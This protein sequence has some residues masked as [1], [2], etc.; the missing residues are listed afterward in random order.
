MNT[1]QVNL[2]TVPPGAATDPIAQAEKAFRARKKKERPVR[3]PEL[4][5]HLRLNDEYAA[6]KQAEADDK[7]RRKKLGLPKKVKSDADKA[8]EQAYQKRWLQACRALVL[9]D[10]QPPAFADL[11]AEVRRRA[12]EPPGT[13]SLRA[14]REGWDKES[15]IFLN[16][17]AGQ[18]SVAMLVLA[19]LGLLP[20]WMRNHRLV[21]MFADVMCER[22]STYALLMHHLVPFM[23]RHR[24]EFRWLKPQGYYF[25]LNT[26]VPALAWLD[27]G[28]AQTE[29]TSEFHVTKNRV[30]P[31]L[32]HIY[33][34]DKHPSFPMWNS[35]ARCNGNS[36]HGVLARAR[37]FVRKEMNGRGAKSQT[38][39]GFKDWVLLGIAQDEPKRAEPTMEQNY[40]ILYPLIGYQLGREDC[41]QLILAAGL[42]PVE[43]SGCVT[44]FAAPTWER[45]YVSQV[46]PEVFSQMVLMENLSIA[47][48]VARGLQ[49]N[50]IDLEYNLPLEEAVAAYQRDNAN[51]TVEMCADWL[52][53][54]TY[55]RDDRPAS[56][57]GANPDQLSFDLDGLDPDDVLE[58]LEAVEE[59][60]LAE[61][62]D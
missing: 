4:E 21:I 15:V 23:Q 17:G 62:G 11:L 41:L 51:V 28:V 13:Y 48:R 18:D 49:P 60:A 30:L 6:R 52:I 10:E 1:V 2:F 35:R 50:Y 22:P 61:A 19:A 34:G 7:A 40:Q 32:M 9:R 46:Y 31:G 8:E 26:S 53:S 55:N 36:K 47:D 27:E 14:D 24:L 29:T 33:M 39:R 58:M 25:G 20:E 45:W 3:Y 57:S 56:C 37:D 12:A 16:L 44:C 5:Q 42:P 59:L 38:A 43:K 54:R